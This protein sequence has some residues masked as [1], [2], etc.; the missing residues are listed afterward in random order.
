MTPKHQINI[1]IR[2]AI[3]QKQSFSFSE[4]K[5]LHRCICLLL[6]FYGIAVQIPAKKV[7]KYS[8]FLAVL[9]H[10]IWLATVSNEIACFDIADMTYHCFTLIKYL[11]SMLSWWIVHQKK[12]HLKHLTNALE[13]LKIELRINESRTISKW[14]KFFGYFFSFIIFGP[15]IICSIKLIIVNKNPQ[16]FCPYLQNLNIQNG[17]KVLHFFLLSFFNYCSLGLPYIIMIFYCFYCAELV[18]FSKRLTTLRHYGVTEICGLKEFD[19]ERYVKKVYGLLLNTIQKLESTFSSLIFL[20]LVNSFLEILRIEIVI[21]MYLKGHWKL[22]I[23]VHSL[24]YST[25]A[26]VSLIFI[27]VSADKAQ[28]NIDLARDNLRGF[29]KISSVQRSLIDLREDIEFWQDVRCIRLTA[30]GMFKVKRD[31]FLSIL[32]LYISYIVLI[33]Q[34]TA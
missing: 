5:L 1:M 2:D 9:F 22:D 6:M 26:A 27:I 11:C 12:R 32:A 31:L 7:K 21:L 16:F 15:G 3:Q 30:W 4:C 34:F 14:I 17:A 24:Y 25:I 28:D 13:H 8:T 23:F 33:V 19:T 20:L 29:S 18:R 10:S